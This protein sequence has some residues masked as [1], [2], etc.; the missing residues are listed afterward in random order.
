MA[1]ANGIKINR[2]LRSLNLK[3]TRPHYVEQFVRL[4][5]NFKRDADVAA[6]MQ[7]AKIR[8]ACKLFARF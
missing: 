6:G 8:A 4:A 1:L 5:V 3:W 2:S 7:S